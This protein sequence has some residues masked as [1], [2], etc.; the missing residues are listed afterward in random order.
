MG[1]KRREREC[2]EENQQE[3]QKELTLREPEME[4]QVWVMLV[5]SKLIKPQELN[6]HRYFPVSVQEQMGKA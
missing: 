1:W 5:L 3:K 2:K 4:F 6:M